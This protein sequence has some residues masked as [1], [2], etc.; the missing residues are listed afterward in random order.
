[1]EFIAGLVSEALEDWVGT[2]QDDVH[3]VGANILGSFNGLGGNDTLRIT[4][5][6][7]VRL[8]DLNITSIET[9]EGA[10]GNNTFQLSK[11]VL[12]KLKHIKGGAGYNTL[13]LTGDDLD[14]TTLALSNI[15][16]I[17]YSYFSATTPAR[18]AVRD[19]ETALL[20]K[21]SPYHPVYVTLV[22][23]TFSEAQKNTLF[24][25]G[26]TYLRDEGGDH[27]NPRPLMMNFHGDR[28]QTEGGLAGLLD[29]GAQILFQGAGSSMKSLTVRTTG[30]HD[31]FD[32]YGFRLIPGGS[33]S[34]SGPIAQGTE[35]LVDGIV[36]GSISAYSSAGLD[37]NFNTNATAGRV[38]EVLRALTY[39][40]TDA[41]QVSEK[42]IEGVVTDHDGHT[43]KALI[44]ATVAPTG[45]QFEIG[46]EWKGIDTGGNDYYSTKAGLQVRYN[47]IDGGV[48]NDTLFLSG[49]GIFSFHKSYLVNVETIRGSNRDDD[50]T[51]LP[52]S[53]EDVALID[54]RGHSTH[55]YDIVRLQGA[56]FDLTG[57]VFEGVEAIDLTTHGTAVRLDSISTARLVDG[58]DTSNDHIVLTN[59]LFSADDITALRANGIDHISDRSGYIP[60]SPS[61][62]VVNLVLKGTKAKNTL[63]GGAGNDK[64]YGKSGN[65]K[66]TGGAGQDTFVF[67]TALGKG[68][69]KKKHNKNVN[70][71]TITDFNAADDSIWLDNKFFSKLGKGTSS[72]PGKLN[73]KFFKNGKAT[74]KN[75]YVLY[76]KGIVYYDADGSGKKYKPVEFIKISNKVKLSAEDFLIV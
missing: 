28:M 15:H 51:F 36:I 71:D 67:D 3:E 17:T 20:V 63:I 46:G 13:L 44:E 11:D 42:Q 40:N 61:T 60:T 10:V 52:E 65:D 70:F 37:V 2:D 7:Y 59:G 33:V 22:G 8:Y 4:A 76:K 57:K 32:L 31:I 62:P 56:F 5:S 64:L 69:T 73:K 9:I 50:V 27:V 66:L 21:A 53:I 68:T 54:L 45:T 25:Q 14:L 43:D 1:M 16:E 72:N 6:G 41:L 48:H 19:F 12:P 38:Q 39:T 30:F 29:Q 34:L 18:I 35:I 75:D 24:A 49:G 74:D 58:R 55:G 26:L 23:G 47:D